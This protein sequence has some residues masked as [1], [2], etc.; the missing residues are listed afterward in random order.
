MLLAKQESGMRLVRRSGGKCALDC[1]LCILLN[2]LL[3]AI[4]LLGKGILKKIVGRK[5]SSWVIKKL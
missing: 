2:Q 4:L 1:D 5:G 3:R